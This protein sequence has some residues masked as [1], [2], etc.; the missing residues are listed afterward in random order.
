MKNSLILGLAALAASTT[1]IAPTVARADTLDLDVVSERVS[2]SGLNLSS[3]AGQA[4]LE[5]RI[6]AKVRQVCDDGSRDLRSRARQAEC[7]DAARQKADRQVQLALLT[8]KAK[9][10]RA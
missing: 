1:L 5:S 7:M 9:A 6:A 3:A 2:Y 4:R 10:R 8:F